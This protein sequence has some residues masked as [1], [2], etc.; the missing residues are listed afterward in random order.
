[1]EKDAAHRYRR[2]EIF[3]FENAEKSAQQNF[4]MNTA[5]LW[6]VN[7]QLADNRYFKTNRKAENEAKK[8]EKEHTKRGT[9]ETKAADEKYLVSLTELCQTKSSEFEARQKR[10]DEELEVLRQ[11]IS[12]LQNGVSPHEEETFRAGSLAQLRLSQTPPQ[13]RLV[14]FL[15]SEAD[16]VPAVVDAFNSCCL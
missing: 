11:A 2:G 14:S 16:R 13:A 1:M 12:I 10:R 7:V 6:A 4:A 5:D 3:D 15:T 9:E 8:L